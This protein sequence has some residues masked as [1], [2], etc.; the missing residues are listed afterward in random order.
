MFDVL[1]LQL[2]A[3][4]PGPAVSG[5]TVC[6]TTAALIDVDLRVG[7]DCRISGVPH[8]AAG[9]AEFPF[10]SIAIEDFDQDA[11]NDLR[12]GLDA[13]AR[14]VSP[15]AEL[16]PRLAI[17]SAFGS[18]ERSV[19][20]EPRLVEAALAAAELALRTRL[21]DDARRALGITDQLGGRTPALE[22]A[23]A[24]L[25]L[26]IGEHSSVVATAAPSDG[27][28]RRRVTGIALLLSDDPAD[29]TRGD[30]L[31]FGALISGATSVLERALRDIAPLSG[32]RPPETPA[33]LRD[34]WDALAAEAAVSR[35]ERLHVHF[36]RLLH[37]YAFHYDWPR[38]GMRAETEDVSSPFDA[39]GLVYLRHGPP[40]RVI[41][42][43]EP[44][45]PHRVNETWVY[46]GG[47]GGP[48]AIHLIGVNRDWS[49]ARVPGCGDQEWAMARLELDH[50]LGELLLNCRS[51]RP[52]RSDIDH[53][54]L[55]INREIRQRHQEAMTTQDVD[56]GLHTFIDA[57]GA[58]Y[59]LRG[60]DGRPE[61]L[62]VAGVPVEPGVTDTLGRGDFFA[63]GLEAYARGG[64]E[65]ASGVSRVS[66]RTTEVA[67]PGYASVATT[68]A[69]PAERSEVRLVLRDVVDT[70]VGAAMSVPVGGSIAEQDGAAMSDLVPIA[71]GAQPTMTRY[72]V[73]LTPLPDV[74]GGDRFGI[75]FELYGFTA[76]SYRATI[77]GRRLGASA[78]RRLFGRDEV[79]SLTLDRTPNRVGPGVSA[80]LLTIGAPDWEAGTYEI[81][82]TIEAG[83]R[84]SSARRELV[85]VP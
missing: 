38:H 43:F 41:S 53:L 65:G 14:I 39:R 9:S 85:V 40:A 58:V 56:L 4:L 35:P 49:F 57:R 16:A 61:L 13:F 74:I 31:Y 27:P 11:L 15:R 48:F 20:R 47:W 52:Q 8:A 22:A 78:I 81:E 67:P 33:A 54:L 68:L 72:D 69:R 6:N 32:E 84:R 21:E 46:D 77:R 80:E 18:F 10:R 12:D 45:P 51:R 60:P 82:V 5:D 71:S 36:S 23:L 79:I 25:R 42:T 44:R 34:W 24:E 66:M 7:A 62:V 3:A 29:W 73:P 37:A 70:S 30:S 75:Y 83:G 28:A 63:L 59:R 19:E 26:M 64:G 55:E 2:V 1:L 76:D 17:R 50:R